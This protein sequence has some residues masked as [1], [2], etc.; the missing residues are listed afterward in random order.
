MLKSSAVVQNKA[1]R[2]QGGIDEEAARSRYVL[3]DAAKGAEKG[4]DA[5]ARIGEGVAA[6]LATHSQSPPCVVTL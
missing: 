3:A 5:P 6:K 1:G 2:L 4:L